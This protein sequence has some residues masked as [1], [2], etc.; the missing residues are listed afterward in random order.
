MEN[1]KIIKYTTASLYVL[2]YIIVATISCLCSVDFFNMTHGDM[3]SVILSIF[4]EIGSM[5]CLFGALTT[6][7][8]KNNNLI[9]ILFIFL[10]LMQMANNTFYSYSH[11]DNFSG[12]VELFDLT[13]L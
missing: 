2:L 10:T 8:N 5:G 13:E 4:F 1:N 7:K 12:W 6:L 11:I 9:W 3:A